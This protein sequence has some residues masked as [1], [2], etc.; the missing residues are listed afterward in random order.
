[1]RTPGGDGGAV[2]AFRADGSIEGVMEKLR[3]SGVQ[4]EG[5]VSDYP[6]GRVASFKDPDGNELELFEHSS[7]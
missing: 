7:R 1:V 2:L 3:G 6:W 4:F 5:G